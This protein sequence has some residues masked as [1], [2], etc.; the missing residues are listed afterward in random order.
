MTSDRPEKWSKYL[1]WA[2][3]CY[4]TSF[5]SSINMSP[6]Q[7]LYGRTPSVV[8]RYIF[9]ATTVETLDALLIERD[10]LLDFL[11]AT[12]RWFNIAWLRRLIAKGGRS[13]LTWEILCGLSFNHIVKFQCC[14]EF[15]RSCR[16]DF[17]VLTQ[18]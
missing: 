1:G 9:R 13:S 4:N 16:N 5:H 10:Q 15:H 11:K 17:L 14:V 7:A 6:F 12:L 18:F 8:P 3:F 2:E